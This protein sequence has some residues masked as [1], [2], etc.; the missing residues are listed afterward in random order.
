MGCVPTSPSGSTSVNELI[1]EL[2][3]R[4]RRSSDYG[5]PLLDERGTLIDPGRPPPC[6]HRR[7][8]ASRLSDGQVSRAGAR[9]AEELQSCRPRI[10]KADRRAQPVVVDVCP[11]Q[12][13]PEDRDQS[14][15][16]GSSPKREDIAGLG[17]VAECR[18][19]RAVAGLRRIFPDELAKLTGGDKNQAGRV[20]LRRQLLDVLERRQAGAESSWAT[21]V[22]WYPEGVQGWQ[23]SGQQ[24]TEAQEISM[25]DFQH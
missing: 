2:Q 5:V 11:K 23:K 13:K 8:G 25:P 19:R 10:W 9:H 21:P 18:L 3:P 12:R 1:R 7:A 4:S 20:L 16:C 22:Y 15:S 24:M 14:R 17:L 6:R